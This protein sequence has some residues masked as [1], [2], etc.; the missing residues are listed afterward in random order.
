[1][2]GVMNATHVA[3]YSER[4]ELCVYWSRLVC[5]VFIYAL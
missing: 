2:A 4:T 3:Y 1:M 5:R